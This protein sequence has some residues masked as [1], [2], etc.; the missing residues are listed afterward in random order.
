VLAAVA[1]I[2]LGCEGAPRAAQGAAQGSAQAAQAAA[3]PGAQPGAQREAQAQPLDPIALTATA[4]A[5]PPSALVEAAWLAA[6]PRGSV[7]VVDVRAA[8]AYAQGHIAGATWLDVAA[9]DEEAAAQTKDVKAEAEVVAALGAAGIDAQAPVVVYGEAADYRAAARA[10]W[11]L[12][13]HGHPAAAVLNG[14]YEGWVVAGLPTEATPSAR[15]PITY[16]GRRRPE[17]L[18]DMARV[19]AASERGDVVVLDAR[20][21]SDYSG[22]TVYA[23]MPRGGHIPGAVNIDVSATYQTAADGIKRLP[24]PDMLKD[25]YEQA[26]PEGGDVITY[27]NGGRSASLSYLELRAAGREGVAVYDGSWGAW[28]S[29]QDTEAVTGARPRPE[30]GADTPRRRAAP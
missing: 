17:L 21:P 19:K 8:E 10:F 16:T 12:E 25:L 3:Q 5:T 11:I 18:A 6:Q 27:C 9:L 20:S 29:A 22:D 4:S 30:A 26:L 13:L 28:S 2:A 23:H 24:M 7:Q 14:G 15:P 1:V